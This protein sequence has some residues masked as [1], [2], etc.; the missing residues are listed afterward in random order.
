MLRFINHFYLFKP[1]LVD[2]H[3]HL[4]FPDFNKDLDEVIKNAEKSGMSHIIT[5]GVNYESNK[6]T[7]EIAKKYKVVHAS[8]GLY[9]LDILNL[10]EEILDSHIDFIR[11]NKGDIIAVGEVG[12]D[13]VSR[14]KEKEQ[15]KNFLKIISLVEKINKPVVVHSRKAE[16]ET[17]ELLESSNIK[18]IVMHCFSGGMKLVRRIEDNGWNFSIPTNIVHSNHFQTLVERVSINKLLTETDSPYLSCFKGE[19]NEPRNIVFSIKKISEIKKLNEDETKKL[20]F[21]NF[22]KIFF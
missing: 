13:F 8:L 20:I 21:N 14:E 15:K 5:S 7:L 2:V 11:K 1:M 18:K 19:R 10:T 4:D 12:L 22:N 3:A 17:I 6:K 9:P 16:L